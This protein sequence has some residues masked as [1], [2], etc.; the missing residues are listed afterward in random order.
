VQQLSWTRDSEGV[1]VAE[2]H[3]NNGPF[4]FTAQDHGANRRIFT[5]DFSHGGEGGS[6]PSLQVFI[7]PPNGLAN[8]PF[9][10]PVVRNQQFIF[11]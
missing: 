2:F 9:H 10:R 5:E 6:E 4:T 11:G 8:C 7:H 1:L 3:S